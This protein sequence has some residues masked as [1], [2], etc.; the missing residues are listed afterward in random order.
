M[1][2]TEPKVSTDGR[3]LTMALCLAKIRV[4]SEYS[5]V[6]TTGIPVG[7]AAIA[8]ATPAINKVSKACSLLKPKITIKTKVTPA[9]P[10]MIKVSLSSCF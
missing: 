1:A 3:R 6:T 8:K 10:P 2:E 7:M 5:D 9:M 4:P